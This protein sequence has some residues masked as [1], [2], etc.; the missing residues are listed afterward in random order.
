MSWGT[1]TEIERRRRIRV[2]LWAYAYEEHSVS[3][4]S[5]AEFDEECLKV[6]LKQSTGDRRMDNW[7]RKTFSPHTGQWVHNHPNR[8]GLER[9]YRLLTT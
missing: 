8:T 7:F 3:L 5:D 4:V 9:L 6:N 2:A 1:P